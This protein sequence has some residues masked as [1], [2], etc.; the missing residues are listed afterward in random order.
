MY[1]LLLCHIITGP[2]A[3]REDCSLPI[4]FGPQTSKLRWHLRLGTQ[5]DFSF[6]LH[7]GKGLIARSKRKFTQ[8]FHHYSPKYDSSSIRQSFL[9][10]DT[11]PFKNGSLVDLCVGIDCLVLFILFLRCIL[12][13]CYRMPRSDGM[14]HHGARSFVAFLVIAVITTHGRCLF[15]E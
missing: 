5:T 2:M 3:N 10:V 9:L 8:T 15:R 7:G 11:L 14:H 12:G 6:F 13:Q 4:S 1:F